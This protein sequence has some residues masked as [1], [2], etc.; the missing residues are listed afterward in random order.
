[1][2]KGGRIL[3]LALSVMTILPLAACGEEDEHANQTILYFGVYDAGTGFDS[4][5]E[6][7]R[8]F[9]QKYE[10][11]SFEEGKQGVYVKIV[12]GK[13]GSGL[14]REIEGLTV[15]VFI[16]T[17]ANA[18]YLAA[19]GY[20]LDISDVYTKPF[21]YDFVTGETDPNG[22]MMTVK[23]FLREDMQEYYKLDDGKYYGFPD[24]SEYQGIVYD[25][26]L[27]EE[28]NLYFAKTGGF[29]KSKT[30][31]R[32]AGPDGDYTT[33]YDNGLPAT[34]DDFFALCDKLVGL[35]ITPILWGGNVQE[36]V[37]AMMTALAADCDGKE[38]TILNYS[39]NGT[40]TTLIKSFDGNGNPILDDPTTITTANGYE[41]YRTEGRYY[42]LKFL[43]RLLSNEKYY[44]SEDAT[45]SSFIHTLAQDEYL[46]SKYGEVR[47]RTAMIIEG[48]WWQ[49]EAM[50]TFEAME[51]ENAEDS[52]Y[53]RRFAMMPFPKP[54][55][56]KVGEPFTLLERCVGDGFINAN[57]PDYRV[58]LAKAFVQFLH[59]EESCKKNL[60]I[61]G[62]CKLVNLTLSPTEYNALT[63]WAKS[64]YDL[65]QNAVI[66][67]MYNKSEIM[68]VYS[69]KLWYSPFL[70][71]SR[72]G[73]RTYT[74]PTKAMID[75]GVTARDYF[76]GLA[77]HWTQTQW[78]SE[79][80]G[81]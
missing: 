4:A 38:Q 30:E 27:F 36:Y 47:Q 34:F 60:E 11:H 14:E 62:K 48:N 29:V 59:T 78:N 31:E 54:T 15:D 70:W 20:L 50:G 35:N 58:N 68:Q 42:A 13:Y 6:V 24:E 72:V 41:L 7:A 65:S 51:G 79:F 18:R 56:D 19:N 76:D 75:D 74:Y 44:S 69:N 32:S 77:T 17:A 33:A 49:K 37:S 67:T 12:P 63:P 16:G 28:K 55:A 81:V 73:E 10:K 71:K 2:K 21:A 8:R 64:A 23:D 52:A 45:N 22:S 9:A 66:A 57:V 46:L 5:Y 61:N 3:A 53:N 43:E 25:V 40:A 39:Y 1:M 26:D 80:S